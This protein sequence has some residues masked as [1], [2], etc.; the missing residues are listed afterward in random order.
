MYWRRNR[1]ASTGRAHTH[2][3]RE[4]GEVRDIGIDYGFFGRDREDA[5]SILCVKNAETVQTG[6]WQG[7]LLTGKVRQ[8]MRVRT[9]LRFRQCSIT[10][11]A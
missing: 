8:T 2:A 1:V 6:A 9:C 10:L 5:L 3:S 4:E 11:S 7:Q